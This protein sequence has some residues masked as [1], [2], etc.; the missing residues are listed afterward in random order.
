MELFPE[1]LG[2]HSA[3]AVPC[4]LAGYSVILDYQIICPKGDINSD[5]LVSLIDLAL[6][7]EYMLV[8]NNITDYQW[9][10]GDCDYDD[11]HSVMDILML[12][13]ILE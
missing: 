9:W 4:L 11:N 12:S 1:E 2:G 6:I 8:E 7:S 10:A 5:G 3:L 13:D